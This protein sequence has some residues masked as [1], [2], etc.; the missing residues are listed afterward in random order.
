MSRSA[1]KL[2]QL[3]QKYPLFRPGRTVVDLGAAPGGWCQAVRSLCPDAHLFALDLLPLQ[4][5]VPEATY[6][7]GDFTQPAIR[8]ELQARIAAQCGGDDRSGGVDV[9]L[10]DMMGRSRDAHAANTSGNPIRDSQA[11]LDLCMA[12]FVRLGT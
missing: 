4:A 7:Q 11:S 5:S 9:V 10:S 2:L 1:Y 6:M 12:A 3:A 8:E